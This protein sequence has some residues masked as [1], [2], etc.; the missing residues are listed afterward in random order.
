MKYYLAYGSNL[1]KEQMKH[2]CP[3]AVPIGKTRLNGYRLVF[4]R[5]FLTVEPD[6]CYSVPVGLWAISDQDE[7][8]LDR[9]EGF[10]R[11]YFKQIFPIKLTGYRDMEAFRAGKKEVEET[12]ADAIC[13][14]MADG[15]SIQMPSD[16][17]YATVRQG[18]IDF[19]F[20]HEDHDRLWKAMDYARRKG[21]KHGT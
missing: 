12:I 11:F 1:N 20:T 18:Y 2:R 21:L 14:I 13:Y 8:N 6:P 7:K 4:R 17:Y 3:D 15:Y 10:P 9:Y 5:G 19:D 16:Q